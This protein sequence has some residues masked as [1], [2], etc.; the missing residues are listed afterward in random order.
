MVLLALQAD[1]SP[2][3]PPG[4]PAD[5]VLVLV[6]CSLILPFPCSLFIPALPGVFMSGEGAAVTSAFQG[7]QGGELASALGP[8]QCST[9]QN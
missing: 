2:S 1:S 4:K 3:E 9:K 7:V 8:T 6:L 5:H